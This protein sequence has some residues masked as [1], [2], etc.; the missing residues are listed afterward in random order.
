MIIPLALETL[1][2]LISNNSPLGE[3]LISI[4]HIYS[5]GDIPRRV[6]K[7][8]A[9]NVSPSKDIAVLPLFLYQLT[10][11]YNKQ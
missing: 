9:E 11:A 4:M 6:K 2:L 10:G 3:F 1:Q 7:L 5:L 8:M